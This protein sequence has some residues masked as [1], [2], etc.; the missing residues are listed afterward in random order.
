MLTQFHY[1]K[2]MSPTILDDYLAHGWY[3]MGQSI[4]TTKLLCLE[5]DM[6]STVW[7]RL[8]LRNYTF[9]KSLR[10]L[11]RKNTKQFRVEFG[12]FDLN[13]EK[14][15]LFQKHKVRFDGYVSPTLSDSLLD[16]QR[17]N[18][19]HTK[20]FRVY[21][22]EQ[23]IATS[24]FDLGKNSS[25]SIMGLF[26]PA[27]DKHSLG[28]FTMLLEIQYC[29]EQGIDFY[30]PGYVVP[31]YPSFDYKLRIGD[32][33]YY[34]NKTDKWLPLDML[35]QGELPAE[36]MYAKLRAV[37]TK[38]AD[39]GIEPALWTYPFYDKVITGIEDYHFLQI[40]LFLLCKKRGTQYF[41][42]A[43]DYQ[44]HLYKFSVYEVFEELNYYSILYADFGR[45]NCFA[46]FLEEHLH[47][48]ETTSADEIADEVE[49]YLA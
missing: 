18:I 26:D 29:K 42:V 25:A 5:G 24:F 39:R 1:P 43:Y 11:Y 6:Y 2:A 31:R 33:E 44:S 35:E 34:N 3:R 40:P 38:I 14:E 4:F 22:G 17:G 27:Y 13:E 16:S 36:K 32:T 28:F 12:D 15:M 49:K 48:L 20:E 21:D 23:L 41:V 45:G 47:L 7:V 19:Y 37:Y 8:D 10:K 9:R 46:N 30:Y